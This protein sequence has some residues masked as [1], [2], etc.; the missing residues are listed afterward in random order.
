MT[1]SRAISF[2][3]SVL[4]VAASVAFTAQTGP[5]SPRART[6]VW[7]RAHGYSEMADLVE[8]VSEY[9]I[10]LPPVVGP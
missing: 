9:N 8:P 4:A 7:L 1:P 6:A 2:S 3:I 5:D 10:T